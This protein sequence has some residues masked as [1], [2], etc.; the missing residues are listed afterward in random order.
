MNM[1]FGIN[2]TT[3]IHKKLKNGHTMYNWVTRQKE[4]PFFCMRTLCGVDAIT[5]EEIQYLR[6]NHCKI[7]LVVRGLSEKIISTP[8]GTRE[9]LH[10]IEAA[11]NLGVPQ[12]KKI[13]IFAEIEPEW[14]INHNWMITF[15]QTLFTNGYLPGFIGNT[16]SSKNF[17]FDRQ[18]SHYIQAT[19]AVEYFNTVFMATEPKCESM[20][21]EWAPYCPS[22]LETEDILLWS[23]GKTK[24]TP[25]EVDDVYAKNNKVLKN[26]W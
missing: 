4:F 24:L 18:C 3:P 21:E 1:I 22:E 26:M 7:G 11:I 9:A 19:M 2:S 17:N 23:C 25:Y 15:A 10:A 16:D 5:W 8:D 20:P 14:S 12:N 13:A 6:E